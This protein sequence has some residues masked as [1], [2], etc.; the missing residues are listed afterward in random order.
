MKYLTLD[1]YATEPMDQEHSM[2]LIRLMMNSNSSILMNEV[3]TVNLSNSELGFLGEVFIKRLKFHG[4]KLQAS[5]A[6]FIITLLNTP[7]DSTMWVWTLFNM[8][9]NADHMVTLDDLVHKFPDGFP[10]R[11]SYNTCWD[12]QKEKQ[13]NGLDLQ[14]TWVR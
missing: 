10:T 5:A 4:V 13:G 2:M 1:T 3:S 8:Q 9:H 12:A 11:K 7:A 6:L 14:E